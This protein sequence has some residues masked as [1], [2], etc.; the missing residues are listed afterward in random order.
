VK[1]GASGAKDTSGNALAADKT[2]TFTTAAGGTT[3]TYLSD[4]VWTSMTNGWGPVEKD[5]S[6]GE[7]AAGDGH[8]ITIKG[9]TYAKGLGGHAPSDVKYAL[10]GACTTFLA[11]VGVDAEAGASGSVVFQVW[12]DGVKKFDSGLMTAGMAAQSVTVDVTGVTQLE[13][14]I[15]DGGNGNSSDHGDW[16]DAKVSCAGTLPSVV[17]TTPPDSATGLTTTVNPAA[18]FSR[19]MNASTLTA[20]TVTLKQGTTVL[21]ATVSYDSAS[22]TVTIRP[23]AALATSTNYTATISSGARDTSGNPLAADKVWTFTTGAASAFLS[24]RP[25]ITA[26]N[27]WGPVER[28]RSNGENA[29]GDGHTITLRGVTYAKGLGAHAASDIE[30]PLDGV[31]TAFTATVGVDDEVSGSGS[32][33]FQVLLDGVKAF[34]SGLA[35][36]TSAARSVYVNTSGATQLG[37][38]ITDGG[39]GTASDHGDWANAQVACGADTA[40]PVVTTT[41]PASGATGVAATVM[42]TATFSKA[43]DP[44]TFTTTTVTLKRGTTAVTVTVSYDPA[45][46]TVTLRPAASLAAATAYTVTISSGSAGVKDLEGNALA[47][48]KTWTFTTQ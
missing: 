22:N 19:P 41:S 29:A 46:K 30:F 4:L 38:V 36:R 47:A 24:D 26:V 33:V 8:T 39:N 21:T 45:S 27:G 9:V 5:M 48:D 31:C 43:M 6:N 17:S 20:A 23:A 14:I 11:A 12:N 34:D 13:L 40:A 15:T 37:L 42:P 25:W 10:N 3:F 35:T 18:V 28:D 2:W 7:S 44:T 16:G 32:V 1:G